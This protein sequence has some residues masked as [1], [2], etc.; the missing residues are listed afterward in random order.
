MAAMA[1]F[2]NAVHMVEM[3]QAVHKI[4]SVAPLLIE[5]WFIL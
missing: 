4:V 5:S 3:E 1:K 2:K